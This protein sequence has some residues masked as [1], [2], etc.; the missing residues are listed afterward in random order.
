MIKILKPVK[1]LGLLLI[2]GLILSS[3]SQKISD[4][5]TA[6]TNLKRLNIDEK[7]LDRIDS[8]LGSALINNWTAGT[9]ALV[10]KE[11]KVIYDKGLGFRD[12]EAKS[13]MRPIDLFR[14]AS[15]SKPIVSVA[16]MIL[17]EQGK[18]NLNDPVYKFIPEF[19]DIK[20]LNTYNA[21]D[22]TYTTIAANKEI[23]I[24]HLLT[25]TSGISYGFANKNMKAIYDK[26]QIPDLATVEDI[27]IDSVTKKL[28]RLPLGIQPDT[29]FYYGLNTDV[30]GR[31]I[32]VAAKQPLDSFLAK[33][34]FE[35]LEMKDTHFF[36]PALKNSRLSTMYS[37]TKEGRLVRTPITKDNFNINYSITGAK[38]YL[39]GGSGL[40]SSVEDYARFLQMILNKGSYNKARVLKP[41]TVDLMAQNHIGDLTVGKNKFGL[42]F[43]IA[44]E[45]GLAN[46]SKVGK[47]SWS[48]AFN[49]MFWI[50]PERKSIAILM[51]QVYPAIH[52]KELYVK[53][54]T[55]VNEV[56]DTPPVKK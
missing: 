52:K 15:M 36:L 48:G 42:G 54:E 47:L 20:V 9:T 4:G 33:N 12:R 23:T 8:L 43:E 13:L 34:I 40:V 5:L 46:G 14:I 1:S 22:T 39:S 44:T 16:A 6:A 27:T 35:P 41:E 50:D 26:N 31:V 29:K 38:K 25:H 49:T 51:T 17:V 28:G 3:C 45:N 37:E 21:E 2:A 18:L 30:L 56:L 53:F 19:R 55:I 32:E 11:G 7:N 10:A 24:K